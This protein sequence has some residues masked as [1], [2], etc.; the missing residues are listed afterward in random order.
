M[1]GAASD[2][3]GYSVSICDDYAIMG[4]YG[5][6]SNG[7][8]SGAAYI[9]K[10]DGTSWIQ[11]TKLTA[12]DDT[13]GDY[14]GYSVSIDSNYAII[15]AHGNDDS[16]SSSGTAYIFE[17]DGTSWI[18]QAK[19][20]VSDGTAGDYF[21]RSVSISE[22][23]VVVGAYGNDDNGSSSG[24]AYIFKYDGTNWIQQTKLTASDGAASDY[25]GYSV[26]IDSNYAIIG[27]HGN[28]D[29]E[30]SSGSVYIFEYDGTSWIEQAKL[31][32]S[33]GAAGDYFGRSVS[34]SENNVV[35]GAYGNDDNGSSSG[36]AYIFKY[37]GTN[38]IQQ[39]KLT[40]SDGAASDYFGYSVSIG[41]DSAV[42]GAYTDDENG[43]NS[44]SAYIFRRN[45]TS[46]I[47]QEK[48]LAPDGA[49]SDY[50]G[51]SVS[52]HKNN[53]IISIHYDDDG[54]NSNSGSAY[55]F[56][57]CPTADLNGDYHVGFVDYSIL[58]KQW[59]QCGE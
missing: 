1:D 37:D 56:G 35:V 9:F 6:D 8:S 46:W 36:A 28:D 44:G 15:G 48:L 21:G 52:V 13:A 5:D 12:S 27:A 55:I 4:T 41:T 7:S 26:S 53:T 39:T 50:F 19:L 14:F 22:N 49:N 51:Y 42:I 45:E 16:G 11:Q 30:S 47:E 59:Q 40:A 58:A 32:V 34:I 20:T 54:G 38:W 33:D 10:Y 23:N 18:E 43:T 24:A 3:F 31:T 57:L 29:R 17:Y 2:Y 25:F